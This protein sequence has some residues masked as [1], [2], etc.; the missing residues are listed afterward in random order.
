M[1]TQDNL[2]PTTMRLTTAE[3]TDAREPLLNFFLERYAQAYRS[4]ME[5]FVDAIADGKPMPTTVRDGVL[6]LRLAE[7]AVESARTGRAVAV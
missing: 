2:R 7:R 1:L 4:E 3:L 6:A 5:A